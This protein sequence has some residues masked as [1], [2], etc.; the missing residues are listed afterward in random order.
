[1]IRVKPALRGRLIRMFCSGNEGGSMP[2]RFMNTDE[3][4]LDLSKEDDDRRANL[5]IVRC[6]KPT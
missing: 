3:E 2:Y 1:M 5:A 4:I 6:T